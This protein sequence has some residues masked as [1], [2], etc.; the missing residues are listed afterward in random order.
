[1]ISP[2]QRDRHPCPRRDSNLQSQ[3]A[4]KDK[5]R[6][7][8]FQ[9]C[10]LTIV[11]VVCHSKVLN[12]VGCRSNMLASVC[13]GISSIICCRV[14]H[15]NPILTVAL[16]LCGERRTYQC[17]SNYAHTHV[18]AVNRCYGGQRIIR[19]RIKSAHESYHH[20]KLP[21]CL[22]TVWGVRKEHYWHFIAGPTNKIPVLREHI[23]VKQIFFFEQH[24][25]TGLAYWILW[26][27]ATCFGCMFQPPSGKNGSQKRVNR[28]KP[29][30]TNIRYKVIVKILSNIIPKT[31]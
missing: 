9:P 3:Q 7:E 27:T 13:S 23:E 12:A 25:Y 5:Q 24:N 20:E 22:W 11:S 14:L 18:S 29:L 26:Y 6:A 8:N 19:H 21:C 15:K 4:I 30:F 28:K 10:Y 2:T 16:S 1:V 17:T 31:K